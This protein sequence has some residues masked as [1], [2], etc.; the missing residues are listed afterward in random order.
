MS[1]LFG[2]INTAANA[3]RGQQTALRTVGHNIANANTEGYT[4]QRVILEAETPD[5]FRFG[6]IGNG[7]RVSKIERLIDQGLEQSLRE[8]LSSFFGL[9]IADREL[10]RVEL[11]FNEFGE[12]DLDTALDRF[13]NAAEDL[14][15]NPEDLATRRA[16]V[17][18]GNVLADNIK[19]LSD[20]LTQQR[21]DL[22]AQIRVN[23]DETNRFLQEVASLNAQI[24]RVEAASDQ[25]GDANDLRDKRDTLLKELSSLF[26]IRTFENDR[27]QVTVVGGGEV[28]VQEARAVTLAVRDETDGEILLAT[29][30][31]QETG[32]DLEFVDGRFGG[33]L[34]ARDQSITG[35]LSELNTLAGGIIFETNKIH[36]EGRGL[37]GLSEVTSTEAV[38]DL[39]AVLTAAGLPFTAQNG[40]F[41]IAVENKL[42]GTTSTIRIDVDLDGIGADTTLTS[43]TAEINADAAAA[44]LGLTAT[45]NNL[46]RLT[47]QTTS[48]DL[49]FHFEDDTS[50]VLA[51]LGIN[52]FFQGEDARTIAVDDAVLAD[53]ARVAAAA[54]L[55]QGDNTNILRL[56]QLRGERVLSNDNATVGEFARGL[57]TTLGVLA[58]DAEERLDTQDILNTQLQSEREAI[59]GVNLDEE[60]IDLIRFQRAFQAAARFLAVVDGLIAELINIV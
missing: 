18:R 16:L 34:E 49:A 4:R 28:L 53:P 33:A 59:S 40:H 45:I 27:G 43:L 42:T 21:R 11:T 22:D 17:E 32:R 57:V 3:L 29:V 38:D 48:N 23:V 60:A 44:G 8:S 51:A 20:S 15:L 41:D 9:E 58:Q 19:F 12:T 1:S 36:S 14:S 13:F 54:S 5:V 56:A 39:N 47:I 46:N 7:V 35:I 37:D 31:S 55:N 6:S 30:F 25:L 26:R 24:S 50:N 10:R 52:G 2:A